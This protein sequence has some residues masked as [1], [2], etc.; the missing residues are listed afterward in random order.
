MRALTGEQVLMRIF[1]GESDKWHKRPLYQ[2]IVEFLKSEK[3][4]GATVLRGIMGFGAHSH[5]HTDAILR[6]STDLPIIIEVVDSQE[7][8]DRVLPKLDEMINVGML[9]TLEKVN[10]IRY[11]P[12]AQ[13]TA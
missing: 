7:N 2:E 11:S 8:I 12:G 4:A 3:I 10:V 6:L 9:V 13:P 5:L 1:V